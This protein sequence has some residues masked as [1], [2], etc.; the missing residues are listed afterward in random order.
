MNHGCAPDAPHAWVRAGHDAALLLAA[1]AEQVIAL[2]A[3]LEP[4]AAT[5]DPELAERLEASLSLLQQACAL[6]ERCI[7]ELVRTLSVRQP[8][9]PSTRGVVRMG[10]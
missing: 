1:A 10:R 3:A 9:F 2:A 6:T 5:Q 4:D 7:D 8:A